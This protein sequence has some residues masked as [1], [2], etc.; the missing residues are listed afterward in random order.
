[1]ITDRR[2]VPL[3]PQWPTAGDVLVRACVAHLLGFKRQR[4]P[5]AAAQRTWPRDTAVA[6]VIK[7]ATSPATL[8][9]ASAH[10]IR[11]RRFLH[12]PRAGVRG[13]RGARSLREGIV[14]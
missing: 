3:I 1:M 6:D 13:R 9:S 8:A 12:E 7:G 4:D 14:R 11:R 2:G 5:L 10:P